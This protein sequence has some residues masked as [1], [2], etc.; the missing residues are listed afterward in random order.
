[1]PSRFI[2][3]NAHGGGMVAALGK[4]EV[5][6]LVALQY[7]LVQQNA[8]GNSVEDRSRHVKI[9]LQ[10]FPVIKLEFAD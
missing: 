1:M 9:I 8:S 10:G 3:S 7:Q 2:C 4:K 6:F 5:S